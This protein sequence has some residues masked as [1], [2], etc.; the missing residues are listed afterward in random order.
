MATHA[1]IDP[2]D[3]EPV[4][5]PHDVSLRPLSEADLPALMRW[6]NEPEVR[7]FWGT[8]EGTIEE[9]REEYIEPDVYPAWGFVIELAGRG[10][11]LIQYSHRYPDPDYY[12]DAGIDILIGEPDAR[13]HGAGIEAI[14]VLLRY[15]FEVKRLHRVTIDPEVTNPRAVH[16][17]ERAGFRLGGILRH[18]DLVDGEYRDTQYLT[19]LE[20]EWPAARAR[21][22]A[23][24]GPL[25]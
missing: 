12:W 1:L 7:Q 21:W 14:R 15:L 3:H 17:Y 19:I 5:G 25:A 9:L 10:I 23:E 8:P 20:D 16:V 22:E 24:R 11:G 4:P 18:N 13:G 2:T 6:L